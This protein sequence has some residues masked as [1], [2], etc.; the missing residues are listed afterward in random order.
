MAEYSIISADSHVIEPPDIWDKWLPKKFVDRAPRLV[1]DEAGGDA[2]SFGKDTAPEPLGL[3]TVTGYGYDKFSWVGASY[4]NIE[5]GC[6]IGKDRLRQ[7]DFDGVQAEVIYPPQRT[8]R[9]FIQNKEKDPEFHQAGLEA[10][11]RWVLEDFCGTDPKRLKAVKQIPHLGIEKAVAE[12]QDGKKRGF[13]AGTISAWPSGN[14]G[15]SK[16][17]DPFWAAAQEL[18][19]PISMHISLASY[20]SQLPPSSTSRSIRGLASGQFQQMPLIILD[21][22]FE[23]VFDRFP[24]LKLIAS[25]TGVGWVPFFMEQMDDRYW[26]N[27]KWAGVTLKHL[28]SEYVKRNWYFGIIRDFYGIRNRHDVGVDKVLFST[29]FPH[30]INDYPLTRRVVDEMMGGVSAEERHMMVYDNAARIFGFPRNGVKR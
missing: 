14:A 7:L 13:P 6:Y 18:D 8:M 20:Q 16:S 19:M 10:Y 12:L 4:G 22:V 2:W 11:H 30:H 27:R 15:I 1:K 9:H 17:D 23:G 29:D 5:P 25:E 21:M 28:P 26:R 24:N 3:V